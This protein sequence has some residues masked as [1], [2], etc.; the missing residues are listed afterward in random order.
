MNGGL[1]WDQVVWDVFLMLVSL[2][3]GYAVAKWKGEAL[4][5]QWAEQRRVRDW[6]RLGDAIVTQIQ[7]TV[8]PLHLRAALDPRMNHEEGYHPDNWVTHLREILSRAELRGGD[9]IVTDADFRDRK[10]DTDVILA[11]TRLGLANVPEMSTRLARILALFRDS[12]PQRTQLTLSEAVLATERARDSIQPLTGPDFTLSR[13]DYY[14]RATTN[15]RMMLLVFDSTTTLLQ[16][17]VDPDPPTRQ[18]L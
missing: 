11:A 8:G 12:L 4:L 2:G 1:S 7:A 15:A 13:Q 10:A 18:G 3:A 6:R 5:A 17:L 9:G 16:G 14:I